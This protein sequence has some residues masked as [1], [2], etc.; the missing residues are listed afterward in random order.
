M[1][2]APGL[3][4]KIEEDIEAFQQDVSVV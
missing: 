2:E 1:E 3:V 4:R